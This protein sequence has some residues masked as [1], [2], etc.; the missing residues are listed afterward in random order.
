MRGTETATRCQVSHGARQRLALTRHGLDTIIRY[1]ISNPGA[2]GPGE[3][4]EEKQ[5][6]TTAYTIGRRVTYSNLYYLSD[7][8]TDGANDPTPGRLYNFYRTGASRHYLISDDWGETWRQGGVLMFSDDEDVEGRFKNPYHQFKSN[9]KDE[10]HYIFNDAHPRVEAIHNRVYHVSLKGGDV[11]RSD[12]APFQK[13][14]DAPAGVPND[15]IAYSEVAGTISEVFQPTIS[16]MDDAWVSDLEIDPDGAPY[17][18]F[19]VQIDGFSDDGGILPVGQGG[20]DHRYYYSRWTG[21][22]WSTAQMAY[23]G[24]RLYP[25][26]DDYTGNVALHPDRANEVYISTDVD[27]ITQAQL[28]G[29]DGKRHYEIFRGRTADLGA[30]WRWSPVTFN[31]EVDNLRPVVPD[32]DA[33]NTALLWVRGT[34]TTFVDF[35]T[36]LQA[37]INP[38][39][40]TPV[41]VLAVDFG[42]AGQAVQAGYEPF[43]R[44]AVPEQPGPQSES[45]DSCA[46]ANAG[47]ITVTVGGGDVGFRDRALSAVVPLR[48][49]VDDFVFLEDGMTLTFGNLPADDYQ[50]V[51]YSHDTEHAQRQ[52]NITRDGIVIGMMTPATGAKPLGVNGGDRADSPVGVS[53]SRVTFIADGQHDVKLTFSAT[54]VG[55]AHMVLNGFELNV[56]HSDP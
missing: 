26:E 41:R 54:G 22:A 10:I 30:T 11:R 34:Y 45:F 36:S 42:A 21:S 56:L 28:I 17:L 9:G 46:V 16:E 24:T 32:W 40:P 18:A 49:L 3:W 8:G 23:A 31:S 20:Y 52:F 4:S 5:I 14:S 39:I 47:G 33:A 50:L 1:A 35:D 13:L 44:P 25:I 43:T 2:Y 19:S 51:L 55:G 37:L 48:D 27:P 38:V 29:A 6:D 15:P 12:G 53:A 7:V